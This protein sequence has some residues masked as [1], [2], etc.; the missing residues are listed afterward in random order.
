MLTWAQPDTHRNKHKHYLP[1]HPPTSTHTH[2]HTHIHTHTHTHT[3]FALSPSL[4]AWH[5]AWLSRPSSS[6]IQLCVMKTS[7]LP[8]SLLVLTVLCLRPSS[9]SAWGAAASTDLRDADIA[10]C[11]CLGVNPMTAD[12][13]G[14]P[15]SAMR[16]VRA[17]G[18]RNRGRGRGV[19]YVCTRERNYTGMC[20]REGLGGKG[21][22]LM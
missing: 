22:A 10:G 6:F 1:R 19:V 21:Q 20:K 12:H 4:I 18:V 13:C 7:Y 5:L 15:G 16:S 2:T 8:G 11:C 3:P 14:I 17:G 9:P